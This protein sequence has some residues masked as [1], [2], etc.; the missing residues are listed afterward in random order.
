LGAVPV[1]LKL[2]IGRAAIAGSGVAVI[3]FLLRE[4]EPVATGRGAT[5]GPRAHGLGLA[6]RRA[7]VARDQV[8]V[9][10]RLVP[11]GRAVTANGG[12]ASLS[13]NRAG[14]ARLVLAA[15]AAAVARCGVAI[16][17]FF[18][19]HQH[20][21]AALGPA[22]K[23]GRRAFPTILDLRA[24]TRTAVAVLGVVVIAGFIAR[25]TSVTA[26]HG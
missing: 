25:D 24:I 12:V 6:V 7:P 15:R 14:V 11:L 3:A 8:P 2:A 16:V 20:A 13:R 1:L 9:V 26:H 21:V 4:L 19:S 5:I 10:A 22:A 18:R 17:A 23:T